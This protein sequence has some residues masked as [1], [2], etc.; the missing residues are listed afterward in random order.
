M[1][2]GHGVA[3]WAEM[4]ERPR[5]GEGSEAGRPRV[6]LRDEVSGGGWV[7]PAKAKGGGGGGKGGLREVFP[8][9]Y[10][11]FLLFFLKT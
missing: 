1:P 11:S 10:L 3:R 6:G 8:C 2:L 5:T 7:G 4:A 9:I